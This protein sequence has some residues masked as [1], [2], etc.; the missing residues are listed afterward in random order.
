M[1]TLF[2]LSIVMLAIGSTW[3]VTQTASAQVQGYVGEIR[4]FAGNFAP[5]GWALC[6]GQLLPVSQNDALFSI[7][8]TTYGGD[9]RNTLALPDLRGRVPV[10]PG[11]GPGLTPR[12]LGQRGGTEAVRLKAGAKAAQAAA[13]QQST[14]VPK[15]DEPI[16]IVQPYLCINYIICLQGIFPSRN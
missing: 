10:H 16:S 14:P 13:S 1:K 15:S 12:T 7:I 5:R 3:T 9:A 4:M 2:R 8:G 6:N 11:K